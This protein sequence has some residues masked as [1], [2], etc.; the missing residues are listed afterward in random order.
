VNLSK[1]RRENDQINKFREERGAIT[2]NTHEIQSII[3]AYTKNLYSNKL[4]TLEEMDNFPNAHDQPKLNLEDINY[5]NR[6]VTRTEIESVIKSFPK[7]KTPTPNEF[8]TE[9]FWP[10]KEELIPTLLKCCHEIER[11]GTLPNSFYEVS[12]ILILKVDKDTI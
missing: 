1:R 4:E 3:R 2:T 7:K 11:E 6:S 5:L 12:I 10:F 9:F 8:S